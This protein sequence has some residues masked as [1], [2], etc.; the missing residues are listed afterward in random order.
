M[1]IQQTLFGLFG[2]SLFWLIFVL[3]AVFLVFLVMIVRRNRKFVIPIIEQ[4][5]LGAG[6]IGF[7]TSFRPFIR[8]KPLKAGWFGTVRY[9]MNLIDSGS[10]RELILNDGR[11]I[12]KGSSLYFHEWNGE[13]C[14]LVVRKPDDPRILVPIQ[15]AGVLN[16]E[17]L[18]KIAPLSYREASRDIIE[19]NTKESRRD[20]MKVVEYIALGLIAII[21]F[22]SIVVI[23]QY[24]KSATA[25][26]RAMYEKALEHCPIA[27]TTTP[28]T[29]A[30]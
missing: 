17:L 26:V 27:D 19:E 2:N 16:M 20:W 23:V 11:K 29:T 12:L 24:N 6:K 10:D 14:I 30:P 8:R 1:D 7:V 25:D 5:P 9:L 22:V 4:V 3:G 28:S 21:L 13:R 15:K 18:E